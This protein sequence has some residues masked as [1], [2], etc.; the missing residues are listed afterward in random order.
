MVA[1]RQETA[2]GET[3]Q[4][5]ILDDRPKYGSCHPALEIWASERVTSH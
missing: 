2:E 3:R 1:E 4:N 5:A